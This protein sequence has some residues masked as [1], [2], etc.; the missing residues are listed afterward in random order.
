MMQFIKIGKKLLLLK[1]IF[2]WICKQDWH[3]TER[4]ITQ[5]NNSFLDINILILDG[6]NLNFKILKSGM[7][8]K[9]N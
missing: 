8:L 9:S 7:L 2:A 3:R 5:F 6:I 4:G 1:E